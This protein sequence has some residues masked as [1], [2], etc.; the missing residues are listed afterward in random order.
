[1]FPDFLRVLAAKEMW[2]V[3]ASELEVERKWFAEGA[4]ATV[5]RAMWRGSEVCVKRV[6]AQGEKSLEQMEED[7]VREIEVHRSV[8]HPNICLFMGASFSEELHLM[9]ILELIEGPDFVKF[10]SKTSPS[11]QRTVALDLSRAI[12]FLHHCNPVIL[13]RDIKPNNILIDQY[14]R[15]KLADLGLAKFTQSLS[16]GDPQALTGKTGTRRYMS[17]E[18]A[19]SNPYGAASDVYSLGATL[20]AAYSG[21]SP[22]EMHDVVLHEQWMAAAPDT[23][24]TEEFLLQGFPSAWGMPDSVRKFLLKM[25]HPIA[26]RRPGSKEVVAFFQGQPTR[27]GSRRSFRRH[28]GDSSSMLAHDDESKQCSLM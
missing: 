23:S 16:N 26:S 11:R 24:Q 20:Y 21:E 8:R 14:G 19:T 9:L 1:M 12:C 10:F 13:H 4:M 18:V 7:L 6:R 17:P 3:D 2:L 15:A 22:F 27:K 5:H 25:V 28:K